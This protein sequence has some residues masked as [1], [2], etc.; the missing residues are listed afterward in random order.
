MPTAGWVPRPAGTS[1]V[2]R[3]EISLGVAGLGDPVYRVT[4]RHLPHAG[5]SCRLAPLRAVRELFAQRAM[6]GVMPTICR[7]AN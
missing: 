6:A 4:I 2:H 7:R 3:L 1:P 5:S